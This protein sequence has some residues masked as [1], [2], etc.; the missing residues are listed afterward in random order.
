L[1]LCIE[2]KNRNIFLTLLLFLT[3][4]AACSGGR[5]RDLD[6]EEVKH[7]WAENL[8]KNRAKYPDNFPWKHPEKRV[9]YQSDF[10]VYMFSD[11]FAQ[12]DA[13][14]LEIVPGEKIEDYKIFF[15]KREILLTETAWGYKGLFGI[16]PNHP[17]GKAELEIAYEDFMQARR[18]SL[19]FDVKKKKFPV[20]KTL[21]KLGKY[22][23]LSELRKP[24]VKKFIKEC[25]QKKKEAFS[26]SEENLLTSNFSHPLKNHVVTSEFWAR[27]IK[28]KYDK[29]RK[30]R[31]KQ[32]N[33]THK[34]LDLA[35]A[36]G[37]PIFAVADG[38]VALS[39][40]MYFEGYYTLIDHGN[41]IYSG[42]MHQNKTYVEKD[43]TIEAGD[44]IGEVGSSGA[45]TG[46][47][48]HVF[49]M[50]QGVMVDPMSLLVLPYRE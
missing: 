10:V 31:K 24:E 6:Y 32:K 37:T 34:G 43:D 36:N 35:G 17:A 16:E 3:A 45:V 18:Q 47:H 46:P 2:N 14:Y 7:R 29:A 11:Q 22:S 1:R 21:L 9:F 5:F 25:L 49:V 13:V 20:S 15:N 50:I 4:Y 39:E 38:K 28:Y 48:L 23:D 41:K 19:P 8:E 12:G 27:R 44:K 26:K 40:K 30:K 33:S 42:Y